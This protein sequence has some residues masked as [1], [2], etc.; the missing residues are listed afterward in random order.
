VRHS[1]ATT[2]V[3][4]MNFWCSILRQFSDDNGTL[5]LEPTGNFTYHKGFNIKNFYKVITWNLRVLFRSRNK[6]QILPYTSLKD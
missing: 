2:V 5:A 3:Y 6:Q 1:S 4:I